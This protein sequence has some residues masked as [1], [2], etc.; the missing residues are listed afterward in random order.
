L[1]DW[2]ISGFGRATRAYARTTS[3][4]YAEQASI[5]RWARDVIRSGVAVY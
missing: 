5:Q 4:N 2:R 1:E 3:V